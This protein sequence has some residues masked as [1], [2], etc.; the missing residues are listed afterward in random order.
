MPGA[1]AANNADRDA[2]AF[3]HA[4]TRAAVVTSL[5][6]ELPVGL[7]VL[8]PVAGLAVGVLRWWPDR[9]V[10]ALAPALVAVSAVAVLPTT[11]RLAVYAVSDIGFDPVWIG[12]AVLTWAAAR[13]A[14]AGVVALVVAAVRGRRR[15]APPAAA[16]LARS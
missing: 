6:V 16:D 5:L 3:R 13:C 2:M 14:A 7:A 9:R 12:L 8:G 1:S 4:L 10:A 11:V 15:A